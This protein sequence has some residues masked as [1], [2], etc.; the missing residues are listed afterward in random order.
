[1]FFNKKPENADDFP[2]VKEV[3]EL[4]GSFSFTTLEIAK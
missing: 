3:V 4:S 2:A 1:M